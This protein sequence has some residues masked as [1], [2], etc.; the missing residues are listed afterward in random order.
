MLIK[1]RLL[2]RITIMNCV[3]RSNARHRTEKCAVM[4]AEWQRRLH[5]AAGPD[6]A[7]TSCLVTVSL[8]LEGREGS[9]Q[10]IILYP[11]GRQHAV[12]LLISNYPQILW[13]WRRV[14]ESEWR[15]AVAVQSRSRLRTSHCKS[16]WLISNFAQQQKES[17]DGSLFCFL[18][19]NKVISQT[20]RAAMR[21]NILSKF[22]RV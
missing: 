7:P 14:K 20:P 3:R 19:S 21:Q 18:H 6:A 12:S 10:Q 13:A 17:H 9:G 5:G 16:V 4:R 22:V 15:K 2:I 8:V 11:T 1:Q